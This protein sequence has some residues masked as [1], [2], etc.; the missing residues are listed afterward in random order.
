MR[1]AASRSRIA[2]TLRSPR[3]YHI[4]TQIS[5]F[6]SSSSSTNSDAAIAV[7]SAKVYQGKLMGLGITPYFP[8][9]PAS[10]GD[11]GEDFFLT[12]KECVLMRSPTIRA[13]DRI[14]NTKEQL[15]VFTGSRGVGKSTSLAHV[16]DWCRR[17]GWFVVYVPDTRD[18]MVGSKTVRKGTGTA[19]PLSRP[20][21]QS[22]NDDKYAQPLGAYELLCKIVVSHFEALKML[23]QRLSYEH[24]RYDDCEAKQTEEAVTMLREKNQLRLPIQPPVGSPMEALIHSGSSAPEKSLLNIVARGLKRH[25]FASDALHDLKM[26][27]N[28]VEEVP[29]LI[30]VDEVSSLHEPTEFFVNGQRVRPE[31][32]MFGR[33]FRAIDA[34][35]NPLEGA[36]PKMEQL[37]AL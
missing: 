23:P 15:V 26:E 4:S 10:L 3:L 21:L 35:G 16:V 28:E 36:I 9:D 1:L 5:P 7:G 18:W 6:S 24:D 2:A 34:S 32:T 20:Y 31:E 33:T 12:K 11:L 19:T 13:I 14:E 8:E 30:A 25:E 27:L 22:E 37:F 17:T 29:V